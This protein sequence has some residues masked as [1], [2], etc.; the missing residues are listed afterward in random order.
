VEVN[1]C[2][3]VL[4][5]YDTLTKC[6]DSAML[7]TIKPNNIW[8]INNGSIYFQPVLKDTDTKVKILNY[9]HNLGVAKSWN[10]FI[11]DVPEIRIVCN[12][13]VEFHS[14]TIELLIDNYHKYGDKF[15][16]FPGAGIPSLNSF[17][18]YILSDRIVKDVG[19]FDETISPNYAYFEDNDY[20]FRMYLKGYGLHGAPEVFINHVGSATLK[21]YSDKEKKEHNAKFQLA[22][23]NYLKKWGGLPGKEKY[24]EAYNGKS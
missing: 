18:C 7:G 11:E 12:D 21:M 13:D 24:R 23:S 20:S 1:L 2:I 17:S 3:P 19:L 4:K 10:I 22:Q 14:N 16:I 6:I 15:L 5:R 8:I 9:G